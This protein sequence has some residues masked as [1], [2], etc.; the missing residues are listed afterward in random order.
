MEAN[1]NKFVLKEFLKGFT[2]YWINFFATMGIGL[3]IIIVLTIPM[4]FLK[5]IDDDLWSFIVH[6]AVMCGVLYMRSYRQGY[7]QNTSIYTFSF[8]RTGIYTAM[9]FAVQILLVLIF[10]VR[11][12]GHAVYIAG[13]SRWIANYLL[14]L[15]NPSDDRLYATYCQLQW[16]LMLLID[17]FVYAP[18]MV[19]GEYLGAKRNVKETQSA[20]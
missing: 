20:Q 11:N 3:L 12:G 7:G 17:I 5:I 15:L 18:I 16:S 13:P 9:V 14:A 4:R 6:L 8:K 19:F 1:Q 10:G 2:P